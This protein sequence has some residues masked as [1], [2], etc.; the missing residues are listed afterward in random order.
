M[1]RILFIIGTRPEVIKT[2]PV[3][4]EAVSRKYLDVKVV[5]TGQHRELAEEMFEHFRIKP[6]FTLDL[7]KPGQTLYELSASLIS[8]MGEV[9]ANNDFDLTFV[10]G[11]TTTAFL[12]GLA[13]FYAKTPVAHIEAGLRTNNSYDPFPEEINRRLI[14]TIASYNFAPTKMAAEC[15]LKEGISPQKIFVTGN[16]VIDALNWTKDN[17]FDVEPVIESLFDDKYRLILVTAHRRE[18]FGEPHKRIFQ[19]LLDIVNLFEDVKILLPVHPNPAVRKHAEQVLSGHKRIIISSPLD[20]KSF[21]FAM[22]K[23]FFIMS[24]SGGIQEEAPS[25]KKPVLVLR[26]TTERPEGLAANVI[27]LVGTERKKIVAQACKLLNESDYY[28]S[29]ASERNPYGDGT[30]AKK[31]LDLVCK[32]Y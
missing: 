23:C 29:M 30:A 12:G 21:I 18:N 8:A 6:D 26:D 13:S 27:K 2:A 7:M 28:N 25:L 31:I 3:I 24:D 10:Q 32:L 5:H 9:F 11:D 1:R 15:L 19:A 22:Q 17:Y 16:T 14:S 4:I 20:Y